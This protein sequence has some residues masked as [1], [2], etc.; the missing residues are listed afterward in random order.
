MAK[1]KVIIMGAAGRDFHNFNT[2]YRD[3]EDYEV[4]AFT[5]TQIPDIEGRLYPP[6]LAGKLYPEG[7]PIHPEDDLPDLIDKFDV[8]DVVFSYSDVSYEY[9]MGAGAWAM[10]CGAKNFVL[11]GPEPTMIDSDVPVI[12]VCATRTGCGKSQT[13]R[14]VAEILTEAGKKV[15]VIRHPMPY[16]DLTKQIWQRFETIEDLK[17]H[18]CTIEEMEEY[19]PH[20]ERGNIV[21]AGVDYGAILREAEKEAD[22][23]LWDGGNNDTAFYTPDLYITVVDPHR[24]GDELTYYPGELNLRLADIVI[25]NKIDT[26]DLEGILEVRQNTMDANPCAMIM[27]AASPITVDDPDLIEGKRVLVIEDGPTLT[28]GGMKFGA[29]VMAAMRSGAAEMIDPRPFAVGTIAETFEKYPETGDLLPAMGYSPQQIKDLEATIAASDAEAVVIGTPIDL[30][31]IVK[32]D[33]PCVRVQYDLQI[34]GKPNL[35]DI[36]KREFE[37]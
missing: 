21:Y 33:K 16:G 30:R 31:R 35:E 28:H 24:P 7:I 22:F 26:A 6:E 11:I 9:V 8:D 29:G 4:V 27:E 17:K 13:T 34:I 23:I 18:E 3:N 25:I 36:I 37:L 10:S 14:R 12:A 5:A 19:E 15:A 1:R 2:I 32:I 20:I